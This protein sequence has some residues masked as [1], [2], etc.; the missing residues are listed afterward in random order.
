MKPL[1]IGIAGVRGIGG[2]TYL[3]SIT[4]YRPHQVSSPPKLGLVFECRALRS[5]SLPHEL[6]FRQSASDTSTSATSFGVSGPERAADSG[7]GA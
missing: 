4:R 7:L 1:K 5:A 3:G 6:H 2:E